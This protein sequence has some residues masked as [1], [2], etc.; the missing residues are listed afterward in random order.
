MIAPDVVS[1]IRELLRGGRVS[2]RKIAQQ[3]GVS[4]GTVNAIACGRRP[5][6]TA[7]RD[8]NGWEVPAASGPSMRCPGCGGLVRMPCLACRVRA[9]RRQRRP[10]VGAR[11]HRQGR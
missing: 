3:V 4:R 7:R 1:R 8:D 2:Q 6:Y 5:D 10:G 11:P 9:M